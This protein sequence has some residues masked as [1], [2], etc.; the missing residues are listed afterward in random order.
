MS[1]FPS[2]S[3]DD[4]EFGVITAADARIFGGLHLL[5]SSIPAV[6]MAVVDL[7]LHD[8]HLQWLRDHDCRILPAVGTVERNVLWWQTW[9]K[10]FYLQSSPFRRTLWLDA[11]TVVVGSMTPMVARLQR[12]GFV[13]I[14]QLLHGLPHSMGGRFYQEFPVQLPFPGIQAGVVGISKDSLEDQAL[15][16]VWLDTVELAS[17]PEWR[18]CMPWADNDALDWTMAS[19]RDVD[20]IVTD[21]QWN[22]YF[23]EDK[24]WRSTNRQRLLGMIEERTTPGDI[25]LHLCHKPWLPIRKLKQ[26]RKHEVHKTARLTPLSVPVQEALGSQPAGNPTPGA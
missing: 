6:P 14:H 12:R 20:F 22:H 11:D 16:S 17:K 3:I 21:T 13:V 8:D 24:H 19:T 1:V 18:R 5:R 25:V 23:H 4:P 7:G 2:Q 15:L 9:N 10:P 26:L